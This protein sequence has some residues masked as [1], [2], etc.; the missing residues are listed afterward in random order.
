LELEKEI[1]GMLLFLFSPGLSGILQGEW[2]SWDI[3]T[4]PC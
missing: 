2:L 1:L 4:G 3:G